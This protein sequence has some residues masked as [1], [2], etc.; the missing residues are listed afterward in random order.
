MSEIRLI[1]KNTD[2]KK[3]PIKP[4]DWD[5]V[6]RGIPYYV[7][8][9]EGYI[10]TIG[11]KWGNNDYWCWPRDEEP[12]YENIIE[13]NSDHVVCWG[14]NYSES[15]YQ[16]NKWDES[17]LEGTSGAMITRNGQDF[18]FVNGTM[19]YSINKAK[20]LIT[21]LNEGMAINFNSINY[22]KEIVNREILYK[23]IPAII[24]RWVS[25]QGYIIIE[26]TG[27]D[28]YEN[29]IL[30]YWNCD[31]VYFVTLDI[32]GY[33]HYDIDWYPS[34]ERNILNKLDKNYEINIKG[35]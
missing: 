25:G 33:D 7:A 30:D 28:K 34:S 32:I 24:R 3:L 14:I 16:K 9:I 18:Y 22:V 23:G 20:L 21:K 27:P 8:R 10:H 13:F 26:Y 6:F 31:D 19:D 15:F 1:D 11:G 35:E 29:F 2:I 5:V 12:S 4:T 17:S